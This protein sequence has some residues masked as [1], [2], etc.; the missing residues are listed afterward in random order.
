MG[1]QSYSPAVVTEQHQAEAGIIG[2]RGNPVSSNPFR[3]FQHLS[4]CIK[5]DVSQ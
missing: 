3:H 4:L 2:S 5:L 1:S